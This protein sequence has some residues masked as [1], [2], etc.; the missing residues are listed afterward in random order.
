MPRFNAR[1]ELHPYGRYVSAPANSM[2]NSN[3]GWVF[4]PAALP[5]A[6]PLAFLEPLLRRTTDRILATSLAIGSGAEPSVSW[7]PVHD[8]SAQAR[9]LELSSTGLED[10]LCALHRLVAAHSEVEGPVGRLRRS[11]NVVF[12]NG[13]YSVDVLIPSPAAASLRELLTQLEGFIGSANFLDPLIN[14]ILINIQIIC[15]QP[16]QDGNSRVAG[17]V[18]ENRL[19][20]SAILGDYLLPI[21]GGIAACNSPIFDTVYQAVRWNSWTPYVT[22]MLDIIDLATTLMLPA[23][24]RTTGQTPGPGGA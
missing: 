19:R 9:G 3:H 16:F 8:L 1:P 24:P 18:L 21:R 14:A 11:E 15:I 4:V 13:A 2:A 20:S 5:P 6:L 23:S 12:R 17:L 10:Y 7:G 22:F